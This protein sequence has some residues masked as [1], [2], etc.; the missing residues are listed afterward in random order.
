MWAPFFSLLIRPNDKEVP[1]NRFAALLL[2]AVVVAAVTAA[3][4]PRPGSWVAGWD[5]PVDPKGD[6]KFDRRGEKLSITVPGEGHDLDAREA[7]PR[8]MREVEG[9]FAVQVRVG[10]NIRPADP[11]G[12]GWRQAG[13]LLAEGTDIKLR[14][15][16]GLFRWLEI[17]GRGV[18]SVRWVP[19]LCLGPLSS[20]RSVDYHAGLPVRL[21]LERRGGAVRMAFAPDGKGWS[22]LGPP[23]DVKLSLKVKVGVV[24]SSSAPGPFKAVFDQFRLTPLGGE[25]R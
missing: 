11:E 22:P 25:S 9:D 19:Q 18:A 17:D 1:M 14:L 12:P 3:P 2:F 23:Q 4:V 5:R 20:P 8:L 10:G 15:T 13:L 24:A 7:A 21:R 16:T 6:C